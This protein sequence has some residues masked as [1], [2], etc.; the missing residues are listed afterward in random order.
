[1]AVEDSPI[2]LPEGVSQRQIADAIGISISTV[3]RALSGNDKVSDRTRADVLRAIDRLT[4]PQDPSGA[5]SPARKV[6]GLTHSHLV[7]GPA[8]RSL[9]I[10]LE[11]VLGGAEI[12]ARKA[13][14]ML[15]TVQNSQMLKGRT[16]ATPSSPRSR[17]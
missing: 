4:R 5:A 8:L 7:E 9:D 16:P 11:Q 6:I 13:G 3:S 2:L 1:M 14:Y 15:Y 10:I 17:A 12:A